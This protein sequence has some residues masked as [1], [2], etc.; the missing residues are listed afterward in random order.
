MYSSVPR[1]FEWG[2]YKHNQIYLVENFFQVVKK[3]FSLNLSLISRI[4][5]LQGGE[6]WHNA[7]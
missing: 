3:V 4:S 2:T 6:P 1:I 7:F 5:D